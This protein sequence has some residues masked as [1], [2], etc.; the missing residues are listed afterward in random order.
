MKRALYKVII[1]PI[2][3]LDRYTLHEGELNIF[4]IVVFHIGKV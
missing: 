2:C 4:L 1:G 3:R